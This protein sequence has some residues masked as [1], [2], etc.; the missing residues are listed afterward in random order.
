MAATTQRKGLGSEQSQYITAQ[1]I[2]VVGGY[3]LR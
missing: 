1:A 2:N 3:G